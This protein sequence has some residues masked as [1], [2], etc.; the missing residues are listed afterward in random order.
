MSLAKKFTVKESQTVGFRTE[1]FN[2]FNH[3][4][5]INPSANVALGSFGQI[6]AT[7]LNLRLIQFAL[8]YLF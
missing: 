3:P 4:Q 2:T 5:F 6:G 1:F 7:A 8:K